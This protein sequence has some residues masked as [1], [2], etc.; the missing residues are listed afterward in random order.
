MCGK[1]DFNIKRDA[2][3][4]KKY[5][6]LLLLI[7]TAEA[8]FA[9]P[10][11]P[12]TDG[13]RDGSKRPF[14]ESRFQRVSSFSVS[15]ERSTARS[16]SCTGT[17]DLLVI[18]IGFKDKHF[19]PER[20]SSCYEKLLE[21]DEDSLT[22]TQYYKDMSNG[23][24]D[25][26]FTVLGPYVAA[27]Y[28]SYYGKNRPHD[29]IDAHAAALVREAIENAK[30]E[31]AGGFSKFDN[32]GDGYVDTVIVI[33]AG[34]GEEEC[35]KDD[36]WSHHWTLSAANKYDDGYEAITT[37]EDKTFDS[38]TIQPEYYHC[39]K[40]RPTIGVFCHEYG[41]TLGLDDLYD[42]T[43]ETSGVGKWSLMGSGAWGSSCG[44]DPAPLLGWERDKL[45]WLSSETI[46][47][48]KN[49]PLH[50]TGSDIEAPEG[51]VY[52][53]DLTANG[54]QYLL[55]EGKKSSVPGEGK[56][57]PESG[58]LICQIHERVIDRYYRYNGINN[59]KKRVHGINILEA[60]SGNYD[61]YGRGALWN[62]N[63]SDDDKPVLFRSDTKT[64]L[65][66]SQNI[67]AGGSPFSFIFPVFMIAAAS[68][69][70]ISLFLI[71]IGKF[72]F[73]PA[74][75]SLSILFSVSCDFSGGGAQLFY[76]HP[77]S[78]YY[79]DMDDVS[80]K[81]GVSGICITDIS[82]DDEEGTFSFNVQKK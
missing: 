54:K 7:L 78:N 19:A 20:D 72:Y 27:N 63:I 49:E 48:P 51:K 53:I 13:R 9:M 66:P 64:D 82:T 3:H 28:H 60:A 15:S 32:D 25:L 5:L 16:S 21:T 46:T 50:I 61:L 10:P 80:S 6:F 30:D 17:R 65:L 4:K 45:G 22:M 42:T 70:I 14:D 12:G 57:V 56:Y 81:G 29:G 36:I 8:L 31:Y 59:T 75:L 34:T 79:T 68:L 26:H 18:L 33:H 38:Y 41:H 71:R 39:A 35:D 23:E 52:K 55:L 2:L 1:V 24:L 11:F 40:D 62:S 47:P 69:Y 44:S 73:L 37:A 77:N 74:A 67:F 58:L 76:R 43:S